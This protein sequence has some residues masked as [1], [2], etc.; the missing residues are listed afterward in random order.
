MATVSSLSEVSRPISCLRSVRAL[1][2]VCDCLKMT[3]VAKTGRAVEI[4]ML[5]VFDSPECLDKKDPLGV[6]DTQFEL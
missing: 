3:R 6:Y 4:K 2:C 1:N 5:N